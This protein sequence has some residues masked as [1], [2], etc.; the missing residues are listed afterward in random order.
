MTKV[1]FFI[2]GIGDLSGGGGAERFF[3][4]FFDLYL[5]SKY[6]QFKLFYI[7]DKLSLRQ[8][9]KVGKLNANSQ[10]LIFKIVS[11][12]LKFIF[13]NYQIIKLIVFNNI[14]VIH[15][16]LYNITYIPILKTINRIPFFCRPKIVINI[17]NCYI[18]PWLSNVNHPNYTITSKVYYPLFNQIDVTGYFSWYENFKQYAEHIKFK[19]APKIIYAITSR[20]SNTETFYPGTKSKHIVFASRLDEQKRP[21]WFIEALGLMYK[22]NPALVSTWKF[23][24]CGTGPLRFKLIQRS[25]ELNV[26]PLIEFKIE[27]ELQHIFNHSLIYVSCQDY[28]NFPSLTM[29]EAMASG[30]AIVARSVG[31]TALFVKDGINGRLLKEDNPKSLATILMELMNDVLNTQNMGKKANE[32]MTTFHTFENFKIQIEQFWTTVITIDNPNK[33]NFIS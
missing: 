13:E 22:T 11:N 27:A 29:A 26:Y 20:F 6:Q 9:N 25:K 2:Y 10:L 32:L 12:R 7:I 33:F 16:P 23:I 5:K 1:A 8:L 17:S 31:Q 21:D 3:A 18:V 28:E 30:N 24:F 14:K 4:D 19:K 15:L